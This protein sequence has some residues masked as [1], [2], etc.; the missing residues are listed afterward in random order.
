[1]NLREALINQGNSPEETDEIISGMV[2]DINNGADPEELLWD[3]GL[4][5]DYVFDL[6]EAGL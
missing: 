4:E 3:Q 5:S 2:E 6:L 1:M